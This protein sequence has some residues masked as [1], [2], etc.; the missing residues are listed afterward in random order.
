MIDIRLGKWS[1]SIIADSLFLYSFLNSL[2]FFF[3]IILI[4]NIVNFSKLQ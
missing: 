4:F 2:G 3:L 1:N